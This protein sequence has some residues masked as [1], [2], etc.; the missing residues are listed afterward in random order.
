M[1]FQC[2]FF[3]FFF[4]HVI[5]HFTPPDRPCTHIFHTIITTELWIHISTRW[6]LLSSEQGV[7][8]DPQTVRATETVTTAYHRS[9]IFHDDAILSARKFMRCR[10]ALLTCAKSPTVQG[11]LVPSQ[12]PRPS[13]ATGRP[14]QPPLRGR[15]SVAGADVTNETCVIN[16]SPLASR[17]CSN[18]PQ[19]FVVQPT[20]KKSCETWASLRRFQSN[21]IRRD[22]LEKQSGFM[23]PWT[24]GIWIISV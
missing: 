15:T 17:F 22:R 23:M 24:G 6:V 13:G 18:G 12:E 8:N 2:F 20:R 19:M 5:Y 14:C 7:E 3:F 9:G 4:H 10:S 1:C 21:W 16:H 11:Q